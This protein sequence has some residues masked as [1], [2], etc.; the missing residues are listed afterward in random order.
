MMRRAGWCSVLLL[1]A[2]LASCGIVGVQDADNASWFSEAVSAAQQRVVKLYGAGLGR[3]KAYGSGVVVSADG[4]IV[5][6]LTVLLE[7]R[8]LRAVLPDGRTL[9]AEVVARDERRQ[10]ALLQV[11]AEQL[12]YFEPGRSD[13][14]RPGDWVIAA[15]N[16][17]KV[18]DG[19]EPVSV[20]VGL[21]AGRT[22]LSGRHRARDFPYTGTVLLT[23]A[24]VTAPGCAGGALVDG[25]GRL[26]GVIG[27]AVISKHTNTWLNCALPVEE[28]SAFLAGGEQ[29]PVAGSTNRSL[30]DAA[31]RLADL[32]ICLF[33]V[34]GRV[35]PAYVERIRPD[36]P[37]W[38]GGLRA[39]DLI[40]SLDGQAVDTCDDLRRLIG[41]AGPQQRLTLV[42]KRGDELKLIELA[43]EPHD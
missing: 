24:I 28:V 32:G 18:A 27:R 2:I 3:E 22:E 6:A 30:T 31:R 8:G 38:I 34:G 5:T 23:D 25:Q 15:G 9:A 7:G 21:F 13:E 12:P 37:A 16:P 42:V 4:K 11:D 29:E 14:L 36:S 41:E 26:V 33:D 39:N 35:R 43:A 17:F 20:S 10:L 19:P 40:M 1:A